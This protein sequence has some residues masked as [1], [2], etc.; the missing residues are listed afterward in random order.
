MLAAFGC[1]KQSALPN[2][3]RGIFQ[4]RRELFVFGAGF[5]PLVRI[6][7]N[8]RA[9]IL[10]F[11]R[12]VREYAVKMFVEARQRDGRVLGFIAQRILVKNRLVIFCGR[13]KFV[14]SFI[15]AS[16]REQKIGF[17]A[18][19]RISSQCIE[20]ILWTAACA[21]GGSVG[22]K[23]LFLESRTG[24]LLQDLGEVLR[25]RGVFA[26]G[27]FALRGPEERV[28]VQQRIRLGF[29]QPVESLLRVALRIVV[30]A[31]SECGALSPDAGNIFVRES[32]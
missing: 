1:T 6:V 19:G 18:G 20:G 9:L 23:N 26:Q 21:G 24:M 10:H 2:G 28:F 15:G 5:V 8:L 17:G 3:I 12:N 7:K 13:R 29:L 11:A 16:A 14:R 30:V 27:S 4:N 25:S 31:E 22:F 32:G